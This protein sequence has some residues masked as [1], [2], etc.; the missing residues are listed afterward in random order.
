MNK[1]TYK[2]IDFFV[3]IDSGDALVTPTKS[4]DP[5]LKIVETNG[6]GFW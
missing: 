2:G 4:Q 1:I 3:Q 5:T 6:I